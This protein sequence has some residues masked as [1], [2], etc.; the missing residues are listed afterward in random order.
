MK[1]KPKYEL[2]V[3]FLK[4]ELD[5][6]SAKHLQNWL[7]KSPKNKRYFE[8][9]KKTWDFMGNAH[10][11]KPYSEIEKQWLDLQ[12]KIFVR[13]IEILKIIKNLLNR[14]IKI[15]L[16]ILLIVLIPVF[17]YLL[18]EGKTEK[19]ILANT[20]GKFETK[21]IILPDDTYITLNSSSK[22][23]ISIAQNREVKLEGEAYFV[24]NPSTKIT[25]KVKVDPGIITVHG[26]EF[27]VK[28]RSDKLTIYVKNGMVSF[29][30]KNGSRIY[31]NSKDVLNYNPYEGIFKVEKTERDIYTQW[32]VGNLVFE[33]Q[34]LFDVLNELKNYYEFDFVFTNRNAMGKRITGVF[35]K[36]LTL[37]KIIET[38][39][40][41][42]GLKIET[43]ETKQG[44]IIKVS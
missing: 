3:R 21:T 41:I 32:I 44:K 25:F 34:S 43:I 9:F 33:N 10:I 18:K 12:S 5:E 28:S 27:N 7:A 24:V 4:G 22:I 23:Y 13:H 2:F 8:E 38:I 11:D 37:E 17:I 20:T 36:G 35:H 31:L 39:S 30:S 1:N 19:L 15:L 26:T 29:E 40:F 6:K 14:R 16:L 42:T